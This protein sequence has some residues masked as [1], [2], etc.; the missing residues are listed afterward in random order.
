MPTVDDGVSCARLK[1]RHRALAKDSF[2]VLSHGCNLYGCGAVEPP[3]RYACQPMSLSPGI[4]IDMCGL[5][6]NL[7]LL[8]CVLLYNLLE[9]PH[10]NQAAPALLFHGKR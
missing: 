5:P 7:Y 10:G 2:H 6:P 9:V 8:H 3:T 4:V 1:F